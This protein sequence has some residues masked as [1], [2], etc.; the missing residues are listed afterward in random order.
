MT[1]DH[2][3]CVKCGKSENAKAAHMRSSAFVAFKEGDVALTPELE[4]K[5]YVCSE[6]AAEFV[7]AGGKL[8]EFTHPLHH[9][10]FRV[11]E[12]INQAHTHEALDEKLHH[13]GGHNPRHE[14]KSDDHEH[15]HHN[16]HHEH[17]HKYEHQHK[18]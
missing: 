14:K 2:T 8:E 5:H 11:V 3:P 4:E 7:K 1:K 15:E 18:H 12:V 17:Q 9:T 10:D 6:C 16:H 13:G